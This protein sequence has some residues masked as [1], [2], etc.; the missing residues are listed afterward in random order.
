MIKSLSVTFILFTLIQFNM[1]DLT[2]ILKNAPKGTSLYSPIFGNL[3]FVELIEPTERSN[4]EIK[5]QST[6]M[7]DNR[8]I[9]FTK[10]GQYSSGVG[11]CLLFPAYD[12]RSWEGVDYTPKRKDLMAGTPVVTFVYT[13]ESPCELL[14]LYY[15][16]NGQC[17]ATGRTGDTIPAPH[18][19]PVDDF[20][21]EDLTWDP[22]DDYGSQCNAKDEELDILGIIK[23]LLNNENKD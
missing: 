14:I 18:A 16:N 7:P 4:F 12:V 15:A 21:F 20:N 22:N 10:Y 2:Q 6:E 9:Y 23:Q 5:T 1:I 8:F 3:T 19:I 17:F 11:E 13:P